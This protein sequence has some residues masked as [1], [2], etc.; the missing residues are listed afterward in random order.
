MPFQL[1]ERPQTL[2]SEAHKNTD[3]L[4]CSIVIASRITK[5]DNKY[6]VCVLLP[7]LPLPHQLEI[8][9]L[10]ILQHFFCWMLDIE[11]GK[12]ENCQYNETIFT[13]RALSIHYRDDSAAQ[14]SQRKQE[15]HCHC[16]KG[17]LPLQQKGGIKTYFIFLLREEHRMSYKSQSWQ[18][19]KYLCSQARL[20]L[21]AEDIATGELGM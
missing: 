4:A 2:H 21:T 9:K 14:T 15:F 5:E 8:S 6:I 1:Q 20:R 10:F 7:L 13:P 18:P 17:N 16:A 11:T 3:T 12:D 19:C